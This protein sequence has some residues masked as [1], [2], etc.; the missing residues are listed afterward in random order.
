MGLGA[1]LSMLL[2]FVLSNHVV[3]DSLGTYFFIVSLII[4][5]SNVVLFGSKNTMIRNAEIEEVTKSLSVLFYNILLGSVVVCTV[6]LWRG[7]F[8]LA[9]VIL[10]ALILRVLVLFSEQYWISRNS[11]KAALLYGKLI[12]L[13]AQLSLI[14]FELP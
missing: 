2:T 4:V 5:S 11:Q 1:V 7:Y 12:P 6:I 13:V 14:W 10:L 9:H 3:S 8:Q